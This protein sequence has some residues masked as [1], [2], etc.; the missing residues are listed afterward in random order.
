MNKVIRKL[1]HLYSL[2]YWRIFYR[3]QIFIEMQMSHKYLLKKLKKEDYTNNILTKEEKIE[4]D[5]FYKKYYGKK[6]PYTWHNLFKRYSGKF[7]VKFFPIDIFIKYLYSL[8]LTSKQYDILKDKNFLYIIAKNVN[9]KIP[10]RFCYSVKGVFFDFDN[11]IIS[12]DKFYESVSNCG[13]A[14]IKPTEIYNTGY[15]KNCRLINVVNGI[16]S[17]SG[18]N[19]KDIIKKNYNNDFVIQ[20]KIVCHKSVSDIYPKSVNTV[21]LSTII[22]NGEIKVIKP[23]LKIGMDGNNVDFG[24]FN[25]KGLMI[26]VKVDG[27]LYDK[28]YC[29]SENKYYFK[30]P[31]TGVVFKNYKIELF[32]KILEAAK[33]VQTCIPW[34]P[35]CTM[36]FVLDKHGDAIIIEIEKPS[37][38]LGQIL[39]REGQFGTDTEEILSFLKSRREKSKLL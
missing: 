5:T 31:D 2:F 26:P 16:D 13:E 18:T 9:V 12:K 3:L 24:G 29:P 39:Y 21:G 33:K 35:F 6:I 28:A 10:K 23:L 1:Y 14:F 34:I 8:N 19:I 20:E 27:T 15:G 30:H 17:Y 11:K 7:D 32:P 37:C 38:F 36:D 25:N 22:L 4:I